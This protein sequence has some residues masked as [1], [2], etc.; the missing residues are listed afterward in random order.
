MKKNLFITFFFIYFKI[1]QINSEEHIKTFPKDY[2]D[3]LYLRLK[4]S[5]KN[6]TELDFT[7][8]EIEKLFDDEIL[9][10]QTSLKLMEHLI[11]TKTDRFKN[12][13]LI[14]DNLK[15][16]IN[17][18]YNIKLLIYNIKH[19]N[20]YK[21]FK[22]LFIKKLNFKTIFTYFGGFFFY[23]FTKYL[24]K[25]P[26][27]N[28]I[29]LFILLYINIVN[30]FYYY[31]NKFYLT[32]FI[33]LISFTINLYFIY[34]CLIILS[35]NKIKDYNIYN[36]NNFKSIQHFFMKLFIT[37]LI[38][39]IELYLITL[40]LRSF[41]NYFLLYIYYYNLRELL[42]NYFFNTNII[43]QPINCFID[44]IFGIILLIYNQIFYILNRQYS[45]E[46]NSFL[47]LN[48]IHIFLYF[49]S[50]DNYVYIHIYGLV[51]NYIEYLNINGVNR[52]TNIINIIK[53]KH[54]KKKT[55]FNKK[56]NW[57][58][59]LFILCF[60]FLF[61]G[62]I[63][64]YY[65]F[66]IYSFIFLK[67]L[68]KYVLIGFSIKCNRLISGFLTILFLFILYNLK[69]LDFYYINEIIKLDDKKL[70]DNFCKYL[71]LF[72]YFILLLCVYFTEHFFKLFNLW[73]YS[74]YTILNIEHLLNSNSKFIKKKNKKFDIF[75]VLNEVFLNNYNESLHDVKLINDNITKFNNNI[76]LS[77]FNTIE[78]MFQQPYKD[79]FIF[80]EITDFSLIY[81]TIILLYI[82]FNNQQNILFQLIYFLHRL[83]IYLKLISLFFEY[84]KS[85]LQK[86]I[87]IL[88]CI[89]FLE[90][91]SHF[92]NL[93]IFDYF[94]INSIKFFV[95]FCH[96]IL[97]QF[98]FIFNIFLL[99]F[100]LI[101][102]NV[103]KN[104]ISP[105]LISIFIGKSFCSLFK[106][107]NYL[108]IF[109]IITFM[110]LI[111][112]TFNNF[113]ILIISYKYIKNFLFQSTG[114]NIIEYLI[115]L[116]F[117]PRP[118]RNDYLEINVIHL[119]NTFL[120]FIIEFINYIS[121]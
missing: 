78:D 26:K 13:D 42:I 46:F 72:F 31:E 83:G 58:I 52:N 4:Y 81:L 82:I 32:N 66:I 90:R 3:N 49:T 62:F 117:N 22:I 12:F 9:S 99:I 68:N 119:Q 34:D 94:F 96:I 101:S 57:N 19:S 120:Q 113:H 48:N 17:F 21:N 108:L 65:F 53:Q 16:F 24:L 60:H 116:C 43:L 8:N 95:Y 88:L 109:F 107:K 63:F 7:I 85:S 14:C 89:V 11:D 56:F 87:Y 118:N 29:L 6:N 44:I 39:I 50:F 64:H 47:I 37:F 110:C 23:F 28:I 80:W 79:M 91:Y 18:D 54:K 93:D 86:N 41:Y 102:F 121:F 61:I 20:F 106:F 15:A 111:L 51:D 10:K 30:A 76:N 35:G 73:N 33:C 114:L 45:Y 104:Y 70:N 98:P 115:K 1:N 74:I 77:N 27:I 71:K 105:F 36:N 59:I 97:I 69:D 75:Y 2:F 103:K 112:L 5:F 67:L 92:P 25:Y 38:L 55:F 100:N 84:S 40:S